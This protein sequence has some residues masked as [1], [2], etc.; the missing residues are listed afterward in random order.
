MPSDRDA[1]RMAILTQFNDYNRPLRCKKCGGLMIFKGVGEYKCEDCKALEYDDYGKTRNYIEKH[2]GATSAE[3]SEH[4][5][6]SQKSIRQMLKESRL[7]VAPESKMFLKCD[8]CGVSIRSGSLCDKCEA[9][10]HR[11][12]EEE[13]R[14]KRKF[15]GY[16]SEKEK[17]DRGEK[18]F[19]R[20][21]E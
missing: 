2:P 3:V 17:R 14:N 9:S 13:E 4:T 16:G 15:S 19:R 12:L 11:K 5:G 6:V 1:S 10:Y 8:I 21:D 18:R 20:E 7:E